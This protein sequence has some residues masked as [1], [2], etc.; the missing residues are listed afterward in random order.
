MWV[1]L[2]Q[3]SNWLHVVLLIYQKV[4]KICSPSAKVV[5]NDVKSHYFRGR[6]R[7]ALETNIRCRPESGSFAFS[8]ERS[9]CTSSRSTNLSDFLFASLV[10]SFS[11]QI[12]LCSLPPSTYFQ[13]IIPIPTRASVMPR[14]FC[15]WNTKT[16]D[17]P[18]RIM[19]AGEE[20]FGCWRTRFR[21]SAM[22]M[23]RT[24]SSKKCS[25]RYYKRLPWNHQD[26]FKSSFI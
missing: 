13:L 18:S 23:E 12:F 11:Y 1:K 2:P 19:T 3:K 26:C 6:R 17:G 16:E 15:Q 8:S 14:R 24:S 7:E 21:F 4:I 25:E 10:Q 9:S 22:K 20:T 5:A